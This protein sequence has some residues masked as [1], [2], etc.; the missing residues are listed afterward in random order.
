MKYLGWVLTLAALMF[1]LGPAAFAQ[2][3]DNHDH[4]NVGAFADYVRFSQLPTD[5]V[6]LGGRL[7]VGVHSH[8]MLEAEMSYD[9]NRAFTETCT[10]CVG[11]ATTRTNFRILHGLFGPMFY[12]GSDHVRAFFTLKGGFANFGLSPEPATFGTFTTT[13]SNLRTQNT[14]GAF[15]PGG[16]IEFFGGPIGIRF[17]AGDLMWFNN[18]AHHDLRLAAGPFF[19][20]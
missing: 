18:G 19:R 1:L 11:L 2:N 7:S 10:G 13:V 17:D 16:G 20:F 8:V 12:A 9:F 14:N 4:V 5:S 3:S 15:Y 6:G